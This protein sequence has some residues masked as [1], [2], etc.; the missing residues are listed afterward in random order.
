[1]R[2]AVLTPLELPRREAP[3]VDVELVQPGVVAVAAELDLELELVA[4]H[5]LVADG[6]CRANTRPAPGAIR[7]A[8]RERAALN[9]CTSQ[10][11]NV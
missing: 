7:S 11:A 10:D 4:G 5:G 8:F 6:T 2:D 3:D 1:M 9:R